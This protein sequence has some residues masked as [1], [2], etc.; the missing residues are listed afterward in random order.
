LL[1]GGY[2][3]DPRPV[4]EGYSAYTPELIRLNEQHLRHTG[5]PDDLIFQLEPIDSRLPS[6][7]DGLSWPAILDNYRVA[8]AANDRVY[9]VRKASPLRSASRYLP[10]GSAVARIGEEVPVPTATGPIFVEVDVKPSMFGKLMAVLYKPPSLTLR[11]TM[12]NGGKFIYRV[13]AN[14]METGFFL[15]P[16]VTTN[17]GFLRLFDPNTPPRDEDEAQSIALDVSGGP[18][19]CWNKV[20]TVTFKQYEY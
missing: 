12:R 2:R 3:W 8:G 15:S 4:F 20:Y 9:M 19:T 7:E 16:L 10:L 1:A 6:L 14:M 5:A 11:V 13:N 17:E 18:K